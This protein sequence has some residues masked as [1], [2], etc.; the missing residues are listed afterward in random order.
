MDHSLSEFLSWGVNHNNVI[1]II[2][3]LFKS[4]VS[5]LSDIMSLSI[6]VQFY[7]FELLVNIR[8]TAK[9]YLSRKIFGFLHFVT[10][11]NEE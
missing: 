1:T 11:K 4:M 10:E 6:I 5:H 7:Y 2:R 3:I 9:N 8:L